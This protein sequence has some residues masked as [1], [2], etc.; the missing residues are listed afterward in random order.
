MEEYKQEFIKFLLETGALKFGEF[1]LKSGRISP[2]FINTG[3]FDDGKSIAKLGYFYASKIKECVG[4]DFD[5]LFGPSYKG[6]PLA[7]TTSIA[8]A[9]NFN[10][11]RGYTFD[12]KE[13]KEHGDKGALVGHK[14]DD[15][16]R[17][18]IL[19][20]VF[21]TGKTKED[22]V[23]LLKGIASAKF[24]CV[25]IAVDRQETV[26]DGKSAIKEFEKKYN[27]PVESIVT[28][29]EIK[30]FLHNKEI[31]GKVYIDDEIKE[32]LDNYAA[33]YGVKE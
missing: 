6:I 8:L 5:I 26:A 17:I 19:D 1:T 28:I 21:T 3:M 33:Q 23:S 16:N 24:K 27:I 2:Y 10:I 22:T 20:D 14:I 32:K 15:G 18:V 30:D 4:E 11:N 9:S 13:A 12:R 29:S 7:L 31:N 25:V